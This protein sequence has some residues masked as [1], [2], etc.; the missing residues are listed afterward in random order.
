MKTAIN[1]LI[2]ISVSLLLSVNS[3]GQDIEFSQFFATKNY[4]NPAFTALSTDQSFTTSYRN[5][6]PSIANAYDSYFVNYDRTLK[7]HEAG[8]GVYYLSDVAGEGSLRR[9]S[10]AFQY[11]KQVRFGKNLYGSMGV[12]GSYNTNSIKWDNLTW[13]DMIDA[14]KG[15]VYS[16]NQPRGASNNSFFDAAAGLIIYSD[17]FFGGFA[18]D[19]INRPDIGLLSIYETSRL[20]IRYKI[21]GGGKIAI[22]SSPNVTAVNLSPQMIYTRQGKN[23]QLSIG[24][25]ITYDKFAIGVWHRVKDSFIFLAGMEHNS[26]RF[27]YSFD[28]GANKLMSQSGGAHEI[29]LTYNFDYQNKQKKRKF[30]VISCPSF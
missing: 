8:I 24:S 1:T 17:M 5:Q 28:L 21:H 13:G 19:H 27:G 2:T 3:I 20:P 23:Q 7:G 10:F 9:Q 22:Q 26:L 6:W 15:F 11:S 30:K 25:Y 14:R 12:R 16:T 29:S 18:M 4:L